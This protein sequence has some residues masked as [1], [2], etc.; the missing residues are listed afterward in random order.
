MPVFELNFLHFYVVFS[1]N[2]NNNKVRVDTHTRHS[3]LEKHIANLR[4]ASVPHYFNTL[5]DPYQPGLN[6]YYVGLC[7][8][9]LKKRRFVCG[10]NCVHCSSCFDVGDIE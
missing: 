2:S 9:C 10:F 4:T 3:V 1:G 6:W 7:I 8:L 5:G